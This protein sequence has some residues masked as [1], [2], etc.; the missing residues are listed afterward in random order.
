VSIL[1][2][3]SDRAREASR[4]ALALD[5]THEGALLV[6][7][8]LLHEEGDIQSLLT[9]S[10]DLGVASKPPEF[11]LDG[12]GAAQAVEL[13]GKQAHPLMI[14]EGV[15]R[16]QVVVERAVLP[17]QF[18]HPQ[19]VFHCPHDLALVADDL[20]VVEQPGHV[21]RLVGRHPVQVKAVE[22]PPE[23]FPLFSHH[24]PA[25]PDRKMALVNSSR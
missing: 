10:D 20:G 17:R 24:V 18:P 16:P 3:D 13:A 8:E 14:V 7:C 12:S 22:R 9:L 19:G 23:S 21:R 11:A 1:L 6:M 25:K 2:K 15:Q 4:H 5:A